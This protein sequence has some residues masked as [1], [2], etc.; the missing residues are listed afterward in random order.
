MEK[1][2]DKDP[3]QTMMNRKSEVGRDNLIKNGWLGWTEVRVL[4][5]SPM[6]PHSAQNHPP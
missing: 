1:K 2:H 3:N 4:L 6:G 5:N